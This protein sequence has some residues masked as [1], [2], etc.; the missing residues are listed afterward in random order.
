MEEGGGGCVY[1]H[2]DKGAGVNVGAGLAPAQIQG[3][4]KGM[5][6]REPRYKGQ[7]APLHMKPI[8]IDPHNIL[9]IKLSSLGDVIHALP[10]AAAL[11]K[12]FP[13]ARISWLVNRGF[14]E[15][16]EGNPDIDELIL[17]ERGRWG[18]FFRLASTVHELKK[19]TNTLKAGSFDLVIDLQGL[20][21]SGLLSYVTNAPVR[22]GFANAR[23]FSPLFY[24]NKNK[25]P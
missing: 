23:E 21:R 15:I 14:H 5:P 18:R 9:I 11:R 20:L 1:D 7:A 12:R 17:F 16:L 13:D 6:L 24:T 3:T 8:T 2:E 4:R 19:L 10:V 25:T 22:M